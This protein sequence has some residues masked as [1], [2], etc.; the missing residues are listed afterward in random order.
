MY[1]EV[2]DPTSPPAGWIQVRVEA[3][4]VHNLVRSRAA[5]RHYTSKSLPH[6]PGTDGVGS[7]ISV[8]ADVSN[9]KLSVGQSVY[10]STIA[11]GGSYSEIVN[12][13]AQAAVALPEGVDPVQIA[14][15]TNPGMSSWMALKARLF[16]TLDQ[17]QAGFTV[18]ILGATS[19]SGRIAASTARIL[20]AGKVV[21]V[22][23][24]EEA[25]R[26]VPGLDDFVT[27][28]DPVTETDLSTLGDVDIVLDYLY[29]DAVAHLFASLGSK[30]PTQY[31]HIGSLAGTTTSLDGAILRSKSL[32]IRG[33]GPGS[34]AMS[35]MAKQLPSLMEA[36]RQIPHTKVREVPLRD[37]ES[38]WGEK[39]GDRV[40]FKP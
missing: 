6:I 29:G 20:G 17:L 37:I 2:D 5:G 25:L 31:V 16:P 4:G 26:G 23:R 15:F 40:V 35:E 1:V 14:A 3:A 8:G 32:T 38:V 9:A 19:A 22:A 27:L 36:F 33:A 7:I 28:K 21:G 39:G 18:V 11:T 10:F 12:V 30:R 34:W 24:N 13:P